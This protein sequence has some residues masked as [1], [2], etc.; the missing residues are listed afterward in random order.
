MQNGDSTARTGTGRPLALAFVLAMLGWVN[1]Q[2]IPVKTES[3]WV[4]G[5]TSDGLT[6]YKGIPFGA[7][8]A[9]QARWRP[10]Q[11]APQWRGVKRTTA[12]GPACQQ[13]QWHNSELIQQSD[14]P[15]SEDCLFLNI[16]SPAKAA[17]ERL[18][19]LVWIHGGGFDIGATAE[20][21]Y[22]GAALAR[23]GVVFVSIAYRV[24]ILGFLA[25]PGLSAESEHRVS[26]NYGLLDQI[27]GLQWVKRNIAAFGGNPD[28][29]T[30]IGQSA[31]G[32]SVSILAASPLA[33]GLFVGAICES[34]GNFGPTRTRSYPGENLSR[35]ADAEREGAAI[36]ATLGVRT[37]AELRALP[38]ERILG[39][40]KFDTHPAWPVRDG[41]VIPADQYEIYAAGKQN[42]VN[43][44]LG[45]N[46][47]EGGPGKQI[48]A[49]QFHSQVQER[50]GPFADRILASY[51]AASDAEARQ[52]S[53]ALDLRDVGFAWGTWS[54]ARLQSRTGKGKVYLYYF[55]KRPPYPDRPPFTNMGAVHGAE[56]PYVFDNLATLNYGWTPADR[57]LAQEIS[58]YWVNFTKS[59]DPNGAGLPHWPDFT[60]DQPLM[61]HLTER[62]HAGPLANEAGLKVLD[63]YFQWR[64]SPQGAR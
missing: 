5:L 41:Y 37:A 4:E 57:A 33:R 58:Q 1:A 31:G 20:S 54:W 6:I 59:G 26:G 48:T 49:A 64:R 30:I 22:D 53:R 7:S 51:P 56:L 13:I 63:E 14:Q 29:V 35:L 44:L 18:P 32:I 12:F 16:W 40:D 11:P 55:D 27:A 39:V 43:I 36:M 25:T 47:D 61:M 21:A 9:G 52:S 15:R 42:D 10:P 3:G 50:Y 19:V 24:G 46:S 45:W 28:H 8:T 62:P 38:T 34:G 23:K 17:G 2:A 60:Q